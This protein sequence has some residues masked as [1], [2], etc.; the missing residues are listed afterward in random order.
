M[1]KSIQQ[2]LAGAVS[3]LLLGGLLPSAQAMVTYSYT[4]NAFNTA[5][6]GVYDTSNFVTIDLSLDAALGA[7]FG[8]ASVTGLPGFSISASDGEQSLSAPVVLALIGTDATG[9][10][11]HWIIQI[12][13]NSGGPFILSE[14]Q[15]QPTD[16]GFLNTS[17]Q[18]F[19][20]SSPGSWTC[21]GACSANTQGNPSSVPAPGP[22]ALLAL[23]LVG[24][25]LTRRR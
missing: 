12:G 14:V 16:R 9:A 2:L 8:V 1:R 20:I 11:D 17:N 24:L 23:G 22:L 3:F 5:L 6:L 4:G 7:D 18:G 15:G 25:A 13:S 21:T 10:I 19:A